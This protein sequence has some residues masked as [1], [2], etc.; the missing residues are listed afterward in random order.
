MYFYQSHLYL[1][2]FTCPICICTVLP[3]LLYLYSFTCPFCTYN[4]LPVSCLLFYLSTLYRYYI[5]PSHLNVYCLPVLPIH[6]PYYLSHLYVYW[7]TCLSC[8]CFSLHFVLTVEMPGAT[9]CCCLA[10]AAQPLQVLPGCGSCV[11]CA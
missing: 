10:P 9:Q 7:F 2:C 8:F 11:G 6:V 4:I 1:Y 3:I 5:Y